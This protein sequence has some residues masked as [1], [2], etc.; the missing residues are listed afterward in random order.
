M[1]ANDRKPEETEAPDE[2]KK[3]TNEMKRPVR[4]T[5][6][7]PVIIQPIPKHGRPRKRALSMEPAE[8]IGKQDLYTLLLDIKHSNTTLGDDLVK[9]IDSKMNE[10]KQ[11]LCSDI[12]NMKSS[13]DDQK[14]SIVKIE[15]VQQTQQTQVNDLEQ[16]MSE[17]EDELSVYAKKIDKTVVYVNE[18]VNTVECALAEDIQNVKQ[19]TEAKFFDLESK[20]KE[21]ENRLMEMTQ[22]EE[23]ENG[24]MQIELEEL[25]SALSKLQTET[26][27]LEKK[28]NFSASNSSA[29]GASGISQ[30]NFDL[31]SSDNSGIFQDVGGNDRDRTL[32]V[33]GIRESFMGNLKLVV[34]DFANEIGCKLN[35]DDIE[36][37]YRIGPFNCKIK[38]PR[39]VKVVLKDPVKRDQIFYFKTRLRL[40]TVFKGIK[41]HKEETQRVESSRCNLAAATIARDLGHEV[42]AR[43]GSV[44]IDG[45]E[46]NI[47]HIDE[48][49]S[50][51]RR[52]RQVPVSPRETME[53]NKARKR[54]E[55]VEWVGTSLQKLSYGLGFFSSGCYLSNLFACDFVC[56]NILFKLV[57][58]GYQAL[59]A[60][61]CKRQDIYQNIMATPFPAKAKSL[62]RYVT[63]TAEWENM[64]ISVMEELVHCK[65][66]QN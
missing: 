30:Q 58:Q 33:N 26:E 11:E 65:F 17:F 21:G 40:S 8:N 51:Y 14:I 3:A 6:R 37:L 35:I 32:I 56:R 1:V 41:V 54:A 13:I 24:R 27:T 36:S 9:T 55:R 66:R 64:K 43:P 61:L 5:R 22:R 57:E 20:Q 39:P 29:S 18:Q 49:P 46:Y 60:L 62:A 25:R 7:E 52:D 59:K 48:I 63:V 23:I 31:P 15:K 19:G 53:W 44:N 47:E 2:G 10:V 34:T 16:K 45:C 4:G 28:Q 38:A 12:K 50:A 42:Y